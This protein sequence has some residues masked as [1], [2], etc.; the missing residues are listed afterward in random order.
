MFSLQVRQKDGQGAH[1]I[2]KQRGTEGGE[3]IDL[4]GMIPIEDGEKEDTSS[5]AYKSPQSL[6]SPSVLSKV[7]LSVSHPADPGPLNS[8]LAAVR[9][10]AKL[11]NNARSS[12]GRAAAIPSRIRDA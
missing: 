9:F 1:G 8:A 3:L 2:V 4:T 10:S 7:V 6:R 11:N 12:D 5:S